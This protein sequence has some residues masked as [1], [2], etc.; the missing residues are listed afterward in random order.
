VDI[1]QHSGFVQ[2]YDVIIFS[3]DPRIYAFIEIRI[4]VP[5][6]ISGI[7]EHSFDGILVVENRVFEQKKSSIDKREYDEDDPD[8]LYR[9]K[10]KS[11]F[12]FF[13]V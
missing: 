7:V 1:I 10:T 5:S 8:Y 9:K 3:F 6:D 2:L 13:F 12:H 11:D 4:I